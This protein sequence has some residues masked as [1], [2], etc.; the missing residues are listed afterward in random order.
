MTT[1]DT[2]LIQYDETPKA[3]QPALLVEL[4][5]NAEELHLVRQFLDDRFARPLLEFILLETIPYEDFFL[6]LSHGYVEAYREFATYVPVARGLCFP[7]PQLTEKARDYDILRTEDRQSEAFI[8][9]LVLAYRARTTG[10]GIVVGRAT[11]EE[12]LD[13]GEERALSC[14]VDP[15]TGGRL[16]AW[17][18]DWKHYDDLIDPLGRDRLITQRALETVALRMS[19]SLIIHDTELAQENR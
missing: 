15:L 5:D 8:E 19:H 14:V 4:F 7:D 9:G 3:E 10:Q 17:S 18:A 1:T 12:W 13:K 2:R 11:L 6:L 16:D